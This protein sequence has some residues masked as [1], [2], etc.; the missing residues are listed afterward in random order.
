MAK[1]TKAEAVKDIERAERALEA[2]KAKHRAEFRKAV[3]AVYEAYGLQ[4]VRTS[5][6]GIGVAIV[7]LT[8]ETLDEAVPQ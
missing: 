4:L 7:T 6:D 5:T 8:D 1:Q 2:A 3:F